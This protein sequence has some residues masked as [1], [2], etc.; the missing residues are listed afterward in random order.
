LKIK[1]FGGIS[2]RPEESVSLSIVDRL[3]R[4]SNFKPRIIISTGFTL[5]YYIIGLI[6][7]VTYF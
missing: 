1:E 2:F 3:R 5:N 4:T 6:I 7:I